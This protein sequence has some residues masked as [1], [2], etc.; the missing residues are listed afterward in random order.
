MRTL[1][2]KVIVGGSVV[3]L[4]AAFIAPQEGFKPVASHNWFDPAGV[5]DYGYGTTNR[6]DPTI[7]VGDRIT[8]PE[9][10]DLLAGRLASKYL[11]PL[12]R[13]IRNFDR[14]PVSRQVAFLSASYNLGDHAVCRSSMARKINAGD[15][16][17]ACDA[18]RLY[19]RAAGR[20]LPGLV[21]RREAERKLCLQEE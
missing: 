7:R 2:Q 1:R 8:E 6:E 4:A 19:V 15:V 21:R 13:C 3:A 10:R 5:V 16:R 9:A 12:R 20:V 14:M 11:P 17:G 18:F